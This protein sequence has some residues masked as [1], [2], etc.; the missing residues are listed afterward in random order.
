MLKFFQSNMPK[1]KIKMGKSPKR[2]I[3]EQKIGLIAIEMKNYR[4]YKSYTQASLWNI[5]FMFG[6]K[7][8]ESF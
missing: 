5:C 8:L 4:N 2:S 7:M 6:V 1:P 3:R